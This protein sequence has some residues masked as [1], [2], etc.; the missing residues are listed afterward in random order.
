ME[1]RMTTAAE[2]LDKRVVINDV[3]ITRLK[4]VC[5]RQVLFSY[6]WTAGFGRMMCR[7]RFDAGATEGA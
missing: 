7:G 3:Q 4:L 5:L 1:E 6:L 2:V